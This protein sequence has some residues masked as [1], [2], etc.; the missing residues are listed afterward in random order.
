MRHDAVTTPKAETGSPLFSH[1]IK[2]LLVD[3][4]AMVGEAVRRMLAAETDIAFHYCNDPAKAIQ[5]AGEIAPT[6]I[7]VDLVMPQIDGLT[8][9]RFMRANAAVREIPIIVLSTTEDPKVK[10]DAFTMGANDYIVKLPDRLELLARVRHHSQGYINLLDKNAAFK[11]L[12]ESQ[13]ALELAKETAEAATRAK[14]DFLACMSHDIRTPM[15]AIIG[16]SDVLAESQLDVEQKQYLR[17]LRSAGETLLNLINDILDFSKIEA[18]QLR[19]E[20]ISFRLRELVSDTAEI[21]GVRAREKGLAVKTLFS[22]GAGGAE[23]LPDAVMG[24]P[25]R[26]RQILINLIGNAIKFTEKGEVTVQVRGETAANGAAVLHFSVTDTG[27]GIPKEKQTA[28]FQK[29]MQVDSTTTRKY[30]GTGL[31]LAI[32]KQLVEMMGGKIWVE[33]EAG[34]GSTFHFTVPLMRD[35][36][37]GAAQPIKQEAAATAASL[38]PK[39][40]LV[41]DDSPE[42]RLLILTYLK[43]S[44]HKVEACENGKLALELFKTDVWDLVLMDMQ[45]PEM[46]GYTATREIRKWEQ[47]GGRTPT[48]IVALTANALSEDE[49][50]SR[51]AGCTDHATKPIRKAKLLDIIA[52][53]PAHGEVIKK[54]SG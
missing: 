50:R 17:V 7:L 27:I 4:Q 45:M 15:N 21:A 48:P 29:F 13:K 16:M 14:S 54:T 20:Q 10:A 25:T 3:D 42:N 26:L 39:H 33:S 44:P 19:L 11:A 40:I 28:L 22:D 24:D 34:T 30:G 2:V 5:L 36:N 1:G 52:Q 38:Q 12:Q 47:A 37:A 23:L 46:D 53:Y 32:C 18:G 9:V 6:I 31:G 49:G 43:K 35:A 51:E 8:L 41:A